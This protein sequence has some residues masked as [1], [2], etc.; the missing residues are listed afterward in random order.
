MSFIND[1]FTSMRM[2]KEDHQAH[3]KKEPTRQVSHN[4]N[5]FTIHYLLFRM[6]LLPRYFYHRVE[7]FYMLPGTLKGHLHNGV[8]ELNRFHIFFGQM[9]FFRLHLLLCYFQTIMSFTQSLLELPYYNTLFL[10]RI[11]ISKSKICHKIHT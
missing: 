7:Q 6:N 5:H 9:N 4:D 11:I 8:V 1:I 3:A 10:H 2:A